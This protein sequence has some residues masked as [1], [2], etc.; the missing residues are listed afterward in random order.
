MDERQPSTLK[1]REECT[2][3]VEEARE[4]EDVGPEEDAAGRSSA[5][6]E[7]EKPLERACIYTA[8]E[9]PGVSDLRRG[10]EEDSEENDGGE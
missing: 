1:D 5:E 2:K 10:G 3:Q 8:Q 9:P 7:T 6:R 4:V